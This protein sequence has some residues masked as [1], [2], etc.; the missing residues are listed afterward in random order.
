MATVYLQK[1]QKSTPKK[2]FCVI[3]SVF[4]KCRCIRVLSSV[5]KSSAGLLSPILV[6]AKSMLGVAEKI[7]CKAQ[8]PSTLRTFC[9]IPRQAQN[10]QLWP[11]EATRAN[12][13][14]PVMS[15]LKLAAHGSNRVNFL[16][17]WSLLNNCGY[18]L[19]AKNTEIHSKKRVLCDFQCFS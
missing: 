2:G 15:C 12:S 7:F 18:S 11:Q 6:P 3:F 10:L 19:L 8:L 1:I 17:V 5:I 16:M 9:E 4:R 13:L 14:F